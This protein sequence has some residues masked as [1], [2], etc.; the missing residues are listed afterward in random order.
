MATYT[1][2][3]RFNA[4]FDLHRLLRRYSF[5]PYK[6]VDRL[7]RAVNRAWNPT[8]A[9]V[10]RAAAGAPASLSVRDDLGYRR[11]SPGELP[12]SEAVVAACQALFEKKRSAWTG[13]P[14]STKEGFLIS[15]VKDGAF[16]QHPAILSFLISDPVLD[17]VSAY[18]GSVPRLSTA[19]LWWS[20]PNESMV[21]SQVYHVDPE[22]DRQLK[23]FL[24]VFDVDDEQGPFTLVPAQ[25]S[26]ELLARANGRQRHFDDAVLE[27]AGAEPVTLT[28]PTGS[29]AFVDT[30]RCLHYGSRGNRRDRVVLMAQYTDFYAPG[31]RAASWAKAVNEAGMVLSAREKLALCVD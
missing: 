31:V 12:G 29:G 3:Q 7:V 15:L 30:S 18:C 2:T 6:A 16:A 11:L 26:Q 9:K 1:E 19:R 28:G 8:Q 23:L 10:R 5:M 17:V 22:D 20:P 4:A 24:N 25:Q 27:A 14:G 21:R 13:D